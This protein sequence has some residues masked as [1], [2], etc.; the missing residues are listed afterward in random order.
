IKLKNIQIQSN[1]ISTINLTGLTSLNSL[2][3]MNNPLGIL[4]LTTNK[5]LQSLNLRNCQL[6]SLNMSNCPAINFVEI[7]NSGPTYANRFSAC[8]LDSLYRSLP[9]RNG[10][11]QGTLKVIY[12]IA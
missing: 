6:R 11:D 5:S 3:A 7:N 8:A 4:D 1:K 9:D 12:S 10:T 2:T